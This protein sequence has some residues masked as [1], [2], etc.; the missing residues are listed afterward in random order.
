MRILTLLYC[1]G[2][3]CRLWGSLDRRYAALY[4]LVKAWAAA[5]GVNDAASNTL[6]SWSWGLMVAFYLQVRL[7][8]PSSLQMR[9]CCGYSANAFV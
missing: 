2:F 4:R 7:L 8:Y 6:N 9:T 1:Y 5:H 3:C